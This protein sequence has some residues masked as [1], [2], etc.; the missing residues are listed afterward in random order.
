MLTIIADILFGFLSYTHWRETK[1]R[2]KFERENNL[3]RSKAIH[4]QHWVIIILLGMTP[5][6]F[7]G[8]LAYTTYFSN[9]AYTK[10]KMRQL[11]N[12]LEM[13]KQITGRYPSQLNDIVRNRPLRKELLTD[14]WNKPF[15]YIVL[16][17]GLTYTLTS[18]GSDGKVNTEDDI[19]YK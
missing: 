18:G 7:L 5:A 1:T 6:F 17:D 19:V 15:D 9:P 8:R 3:P 12:L 16:N 2:R 10:S 13:E 11:V 14:A 4:P